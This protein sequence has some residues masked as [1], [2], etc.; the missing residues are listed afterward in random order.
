M[1]AIFMTIS[2]V[3]R[4]VIPSNINSSDPV[5]FGAG[6]TTFLQIKPLWDIG[7]GI[8]QPTEI[9]I[10]QDGRIFIA[11]KGRN[12]ILV[13]DQNG[14]TPMGFE[15]LLDLTD[16]SGSPVSPIDVDIDKKM[17][18]FFID[19][20]QKIFVWNQFWNQAGI[21]R[22]STSGT[23]KHSLTDVDTT[24]DAG[25]EIWMA[26]LNDQ[27]WELINTELEN[28]NL[29]IDSLLQPHIFYDGSSS[30]NR[31]LDT[32]YDSDSSLFSAL[33]SSSNDENKIFVTDNFGG[34]NNQYRIL[35]IDFKKSLLLELSSGDYVWSFIGH[36]GSTIKG[37]GTGAGTV[38]EPLS[39]DV[40]YQGNLYYTQTGDYFPVHKISP[41]LS[42]DFAIYTS[43]F[44][45][46]VDDIM[47]SDMF[48]FPT[49][50]A[51][52]NN[53]NTYVV[54]QMNRDVTVFTSGGDF[55]KKAGYN[56]TDN[57]LSMLNEPVA[58]AVD[59]RGVLY[60]CDKGDGAIYRFKLSNTL[61]DEII[62]ED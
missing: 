55:F 56:D 31:Y 16:N 22:V 62:L 35:Q 8:D 29:L 13:I 23:F 53:M 1:T 54:D 32:Y 7:Y 28:D 6:D 26:L 9:S 33:T 50:V 58:A 36:Y 11:D 44:Q 4:F 43:G 21:N 40:D 12:S 24:V 38:N 19:G 14:E 25:T 45:P 3:D 61:N 39:L 10:A 41:N 46:E 52:D 60:V 42:G 48:N 30:V 57:S 17:N 34:I 37:F 51:I 5:N 15:Q 49:D 27:A 18:V 20:S 2:C 59:Q 47:N